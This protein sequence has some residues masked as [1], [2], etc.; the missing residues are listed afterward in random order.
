MS[1]QWYSTKR[2]KPAD[3]PVVQ[4][5][6]SSNETFQLDQQHWPPW[7]NASTQMRRLWIYCPDEENQQHVPGSTTTMIARLLTER[8][9]QKDAPQV[10]NY[11][12]YMYAQATDGSIYQSPPIRTNLPPHRSSEPPEWLDAYGPPQF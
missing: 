8:E 1:M 12:F 2:W 9:D 11:N 4:D 7:A 10:Y 3:F 5:L 6:I